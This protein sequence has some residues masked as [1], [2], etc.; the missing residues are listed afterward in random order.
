MDGLA[1]MAWIMPA[2]QSLFIDIKT[3]LPFL[4]WIKG[5]SL[6]LNITSF[7][8]DLASSYFQ[9]KKLPSKYAGHTKTQF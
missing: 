8:L 4:R 6:L 1:E 2:D 7:Y 3:T 5:K 9:V